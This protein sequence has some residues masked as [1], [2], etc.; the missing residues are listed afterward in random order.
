MRYFSRTHTQSK[1]SFINS[2]TVNLGLL[3]LVLISA[4]TYIF[5]ANSIA[6]AN[7]QIRK[8]DSELAS[9]EEIHKSLE[10]ENSNLQSVS[11]IQK[12]T[13]HLGLIPT[14]NFT[15]LRADNVALK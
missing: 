1:K 2:K 4:A 13:E 15:T 8:L 10:L 14:T 12:E 3:F 9:L 7:F 6:T 11:T 5:T